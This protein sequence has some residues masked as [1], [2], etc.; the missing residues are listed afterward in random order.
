MQDK[1]YVVDAAY[2]KH[3]VTESIPEFMSGTAYGG[4]PLVVPSTWKVPPTIRANPALSEELR[5]RSTVKRV[6]FFI[7]AN[8]RNGRH[9]REGHSGSIGGSGINGGTGGQDGGP[10]QDGGHGGNGEHGGDGE[11]APNITLDLAGAPRGLELGGYISGT[12]DIGDDDSIILV[13]CRGGNGGNGGNGGKGG[14]GGKGGNGGPGSQGAPGGPGQPGQ[15]GGRGGNG[16]H[17]GRGGNGGNGSNGG[18][19]AR[20]GN[21]L[22]Q[23]T[24]PRLLALVEIDVTGGVGGKA[25]SQGFGG[26]GGVGGSGGPGGAGGPPGS[27]GQKYGSQGP[28]GQAGHSGHNGQTGNPGQRDGANG[29]PGSAMF[30][31]VDP[32]T[33]M[34][35]YHGNRKFYPVVEGYTIRNA[36]NDAIFEPGQLVFL[37]SVSIVNSGAIPLPAGAIL[38]LVSP[39][40]S[41]VPTSSFELPQVPPDTRLIVNPKI[42]AQIRDAPPPTAPGRYQS[43]AAFSTQLSMLGRTFP[44]SFQASEI[45]VQ[46]PIHFEQLQCPRQA[47]RQE[48]VILTAKIFNCSGLVYGNEARPV[49]INWT[50]D[51]RFIPVRSDYA[52]RVGVG[53]SIEIN[54]EDLQ[55]GQVA[56]YSIEVEI[57]DDVDFYEQLHWSVGLLLRDRLIEISN[58]FVR[59]AGT[60]DVTQEPKDVLLITGSHTMRREYLHWKHLFN[61]LGAEIDIWDMTYNFGISRDERTGERHQNSFLGRYNEKLIVFPVNTPKYFSLWNGADLIDHFFPGYAAPNFDASDRTQRGLPESGLVITGIPSKDLLD[62]IKEDT[63]DV[64]KLTDSYS[65]TH[66]FF[67][68]SESDAKGKE[69]ELLK[70]IEERFPLNMHF[71]KSS[72]FAPY[73]KSGKWCYG[74]L[75]IGSNPIPR[76][77]HVLV[78]PAL[79]SI[80]E[81]LFN[82]LE[83]NMIPMTSSFFSAFLA[84]VSGMT[85]M[86]KIRLLLSDTIPAKNWVFTFGKEKH[87]QFQEIITACIYD[88]LKTEFFVKDTNLTRVHQLISFVDECTPAIAQK[89]A[90]HL[91][92]LLAR[93]QNATRWHAPPFTQAATI[94]E[95]YFLAEQKLEGALEKHGCSHS[96]I[97]KMKSE[98]KDQGEAGSRLKLRDLMLCDWPFRFAETPSWF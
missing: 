68:P 26:A 92:G 41:L 53:Q 83:N 4:G 15:N 20:G 12:A 23:V 35:V 62:K 37:D 28:S 11:M 9:G 3:T 63:K 85:T 13:G 8:G 7:N 86:K 91:F 21:A 36:V 51:N 5:R 22:I 1:S 14:P 88:D 34:P 30:M 95:K 69:A 79:S 39:D 66:Y 50:L 98:G 73:K 65:G 78:L 76:T 6:G 45:E 16:G 90:K 47:A 82:P 97:K 52:A 67:S 24:D 56:G 75:V 32:A 96:S 40:G 29:A 74:E 60:Y 64:V 48:R 55:P 19:G 84:T 70:E 89:L 49:K 31:V 94:R 72:K 80:C 38:S 61:G 87:R 93:L 18:H 77:S 27:G 2:G 42:V 17:G 46:W 10:G 25:G 43:K 57:A 54:V 33:R 58:S 81:D 71:I 44:A 59:I